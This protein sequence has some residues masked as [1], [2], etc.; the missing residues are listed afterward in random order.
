MGWQLPEVGARAVKLLA[1]ASAPVGLFVVGGSLVGLQL[2][3]VR[4]DL[5]R[6]AVGKL[7]L[8]PLAVGGLLWLWPPA[9][10]ALVAPA[11]LLAAMPMLG[12]YTV[13]AQKHGEQGFCAAALLVTTVSSFFT[14][15]ALLWALQHGLQ[16]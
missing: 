14:V 9:N 12:I 7:V 3:G 10:P 16:L 11:V 13:L 2:A 8:H 4:A 1:A 15:T 6:V 5:A